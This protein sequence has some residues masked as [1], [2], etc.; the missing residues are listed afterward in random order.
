M[1]IAYLLKWS[2]ESWLICS[3]SFW[4][5]CSFV[6][7]R[8]SVALRYVSAWNTVSFGVL[9]VN[10]S[11]PWNYRSCK[12]RERPIDWSIASSSSTKTYVWVPSPQN[13]DK[14]TLEKQ[15][16]F[17]VL[18]ENCTLKWLLADFS[19]FWLDFNSIRVFDSYSSTLAAAGTKVLVVII[20]FFLRF[21]SKLSMDQKNFSCYR[22]PHEIWKRCYG[23]IPSI[24]I[25]RNR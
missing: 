17:W 3:S 18:A 25:D 13:P 2:F 15:K 1:V 19:R 22:V 9:D 16:R 7:L 20:F 24:T 11:C 12:F 21:K 10:A 6:R 5:S 14:P 23:R 4:V 8:N